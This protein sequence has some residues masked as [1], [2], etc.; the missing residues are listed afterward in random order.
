MMT[1][2]SVVGLLGVWFI[3]ST[4]IYHNNSWDHWALNKDYAK[5]SM[6]RLLNG[7]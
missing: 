2:I 1:C 7:Y 3:I 5:C 6:L 4:T